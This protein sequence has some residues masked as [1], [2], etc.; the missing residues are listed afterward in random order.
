MNFGTSVN[1][2][3][4]KDSSIFVA[5]GTGGL[6]ILTV[7]IDEGIPDDIIPTKPCPTLI[8]NIIAMFPENK[9]N[10][11]DNSELF[12]DGNNLNLRLVKESPVYV[13]FID[14]GAGWRNSLAYYTYDAAN[15]PATVDD[16][17]LHLVFP[18]ISKEG[19]GGALTTGDRVQLGDSPFAENSVI[20]F[21][22]IAQGWKNGATVDGIYQ[23]YTNTEFNNNSDQQHVLFKEQNCKDLVL[24]FEDYQLPDGDNDF[25]DIIFSIT[26]NEEDNLV[27]TAFD[28]ENIVEK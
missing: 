12:V 4:S 22:L 11:T 28:L 18:N 24:C 14:E 23:H 8:E 6:K 16:I 10:R 20:G 2:V 26:D 9:D 13:T 17:E 21:C 7:E 3:E 15:P 25:N 19:E 1:F 5:A 27:A